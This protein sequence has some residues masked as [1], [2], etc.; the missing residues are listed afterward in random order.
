VEVAWMTDGERARRRRF[1][2]L[3]ASYNPGILAY[4]G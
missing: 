2:A 3:F 4:C 1:D